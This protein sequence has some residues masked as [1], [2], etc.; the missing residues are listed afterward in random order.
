MKITFIGGGN[1]AHAIL[2]GLIQQHWNPQTLSA[3]EIL[4]EARQKLH[5]DFAIQTFDSINEESL[6]GDCLLLAIKPQHMHEAATQ[7]APWVAGKLVISIAAGVRC[8]DLSRW[9]G[10]HPR[11]I[12]VMPNTPALVLSGISALFA[13]PNVSHQDREAA[14]SIMAAVG[15]TLWVPQETDIDS[16]TAVSGS[17]PAYVF[18]FIEALEAAALKLGLGSESARALALATVVGASKLAEQ[19]PD[20]VA[21]LRARVTSKGGTTER[22]IATLEQAQFKDI[23]NQAVKA[24]CDRSHELAEQMGRN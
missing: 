4:P 3:V 24:A 18:Y 13:A 17:G 2:G 7:L 12:R 11:I 23:I 5:A 8:A 16:V 6:P 9:L 15:Q 21:S 20:P 1:M 22:A 10:G 14:Q 19:S